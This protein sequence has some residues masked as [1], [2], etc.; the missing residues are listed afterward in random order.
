MTLTVAE[1]AVELGKTLCRDERY[2]LVTYQQLVG[3]CLYVYLCAFG[4]HLGS[5]AIY[6]HFSVDHHHLDNPNHDYDMY[7]VMVYNQKNNETPRSL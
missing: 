7:G 4:A 1:W 5:E 2:C 3:V 6:W